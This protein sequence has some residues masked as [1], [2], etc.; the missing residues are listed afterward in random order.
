MTQQSTKNKYKIIQQCHCQS[1]ENGV[2]FHCNILIDI[3][4]N[5]RLIKTTKNLQDK[6]IYSCWILRTSAPH[7]HI[8]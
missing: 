3:I 4:I 2:L 6:T 8:Q 7:T 5:H 1:Y